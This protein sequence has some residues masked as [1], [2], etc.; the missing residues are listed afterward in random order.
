MKDKKIMGNA[1]KA[2]LPNGEK[3]SDK[4]Q[5]N[6]VNQGVNNPNKGSSNVNAAGS[7]NSTNGTASTNG[8]NKNEN[9]SENQQVKG[10][11]STGLPD[12]KGMGTQAAKEALKTAAGTVPYTSWIPKGIRDKIID[13][14]MD[15][16]AGQ[17]MVEKA[18][19][20]IKTKIILA[21]VGVVAGLLMSLFLIA[22]IAALIMSPM[23]WLQDMV[24]KVKDTAISFGNFVLGYGWCS[25]DC[26]DDLRSYYYNRLNVEA[27]NYK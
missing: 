1:S 24:E 3:L 2:T 23:A 22:A 20:D 19:G 10:K 26:N 4:I 18:F 7:S 14:F 21:V 27:E 8:S 6:K 11:T 17:A 16:D 9:N 12:V 5:Q 13:K 15:S 25:D